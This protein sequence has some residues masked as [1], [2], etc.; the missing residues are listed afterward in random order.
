MKKFNPLVL[1]LI[2]FLSVTFVAAQIDVENPTTNNLDRPQN[3]QGRLSLLKELGLNREQIQSIRL[4]NQEKRPLMQEAQKRF[5]LAKQTLD[6]SIYSNSPNE[7]LIQS[8]VRAV[9]EAQAEIIKLRTQS[10]LAVRNILTPEQLMRF[11]EIRRNF[12]ERQKRLQTRQGR[13][14]NRRN[15][16]QNKN[17]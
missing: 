10:E 5:R 4:V 6:E 8:N 11:R 9:I 16:R 12:A 1:L 2:I 7:P 17:P 14:L 15:Q 13:I 3:K